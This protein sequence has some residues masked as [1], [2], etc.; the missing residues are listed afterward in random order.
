MVKPYGLAQVAKALVLVVCSLQDQGTNPTGHKQSLRVIGLG[1]FPLELSEMYL[2]ETPCQELMHPRDYS[3]CC[4][5]HPVP[6]K[7]NG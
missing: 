3:G 6:I 5:E 2:R 7:E 1:N 4:S